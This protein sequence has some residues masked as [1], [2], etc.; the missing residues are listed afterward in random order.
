MGKSGC[1]LTRWL[2]AVVL[3]AASASEVRAQAGV[4]GIGTGFGWAAPVGDFEDLFNDGPSY[5]FWVSTGLSE[6]VD[7]LFQLRRSFFDERG[8]ENFIF[9]TTDL[10]ATTL[11]VGPKVTLVPMTSP[12]RPWLAGGL[13]YTRLE[14][15]DSGDNRVEDDDR[16][17]F[18]IGGGLDFG[19]KTWAL[20]V[21]AR[22]FQN[23][24]S[25]DEEDFGYVIPL[26]GFTYR[27]LP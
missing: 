22:Y 4:V 21:E 17:G 27:F 11:N 14:A 13:G 19:R 25:G 10:T 20:S 26:F 16:F 2:M 3:V 23:V 1:W 7:M 5:G 18:D 8:D 15:D 24:G 9:D 6:N 12:V